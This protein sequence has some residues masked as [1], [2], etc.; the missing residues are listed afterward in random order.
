MN[1]RELWGR[2]VGW[3]HRPA[4]ERELAAELDEHLALLA[5]DL[6]AEGL[7]AVAAM[8]EARRRLGSLRRAHE[9]SRD[10]WGFPALDGFARD[11]RQA[12]RG[13]A[14]S[15]FYSATIVLMLALGIGANTAVFSFLNALFLTTAPVSNPERLYSIFSKSAAT[16]EPRATSF[17]NYEDLQHAFRFDIAAHVAILVALTDNAG[18]A[19]QLAAALVSNNYF[20]VLGVRALS[21]RV[22][23]EDEGRADGQ[24][25]VV[26]ISHSLWQ[27]RFGGQAVLGR[28][29]AINTRSFAIIGVAPQSFRGVD[30]GKAVDVWIPSSMHG[31][32][33]TG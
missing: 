23:T 16:Q 6:E 33:L 12:I 4:L 27:R 3:I 20:R 17:Q 9:A 21:G 15:P 13:L 1:P 19:E 5:R 8:T 31:D 24:S 7:S 28:T 25:P 14:R 18:E 11:I 32:A 26:V 29:I 2:L 10:A 22:F 30:V